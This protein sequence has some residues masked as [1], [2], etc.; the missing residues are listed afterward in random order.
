MGQR[1]RVYR[2]DAILA[3][4]PA[5]REAEGGGATNMDQAHL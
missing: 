2:H 4:V 3:E 1:L 5:W